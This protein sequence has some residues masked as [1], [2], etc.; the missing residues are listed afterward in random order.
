MFIII[1]FRLGSD[2]LV[3]CLFYCISQGISH[4]MGLLA[5]GRVYDFKFSIVQVHFVFLLIGFHYVF[6]SSLI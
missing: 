6:F 5:W 2:K 3:G 1:V 4:G